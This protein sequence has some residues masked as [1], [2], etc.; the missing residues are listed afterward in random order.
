M[1][2]LISIYFIF[3]NK[4]FLLNEIVPPLSKKS[5]ELSMNPVILDKKT[6]SY[7]LTSN[8]LFSVTAVPIKHTVFSLGYIIQESQQR[9][10]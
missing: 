3:R 5:L 1:I 6:G 10:R 7:L 8:E 2:F 4:T 9:G